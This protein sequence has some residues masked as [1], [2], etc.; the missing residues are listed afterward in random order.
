MRSAEINVSILQMTG[1]GE[2]RLIID[3]PGVQSGL[4][5]FPELRGWL[6]AAVWSQIE[7][8][9]DAPNSVV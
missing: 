1:D 2:C 3:P 5:R 4:E 9:D 8:G 7:L 6:A